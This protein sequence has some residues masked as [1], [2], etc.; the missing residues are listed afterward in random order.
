MVVS[1]RIWGYYAT[2]IGGF[3]FVTG[4]E[5]DFVVYLFVYIN[6]DSLWGFG[7]LSSFLDITCRLAW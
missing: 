1:V 7:S 5:F 4:V 6:G 2:L 3:F